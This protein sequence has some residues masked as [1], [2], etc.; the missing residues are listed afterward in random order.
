MATQP[1]GRPLVPSVLDRL[2]DD[3]PEQSRESPRARYQVLRQVKEAVRRDLENLLNTRRRCLVLP[4]GCA[5]LPQS[6]VSYGL[7]DLGDFGSAASAGAAGLCDA[8]VEAIRR[9]EPRCRDVQVSVAG[10]A[11]SGEG[12]VRL[13]I[14]ATLDAEPAPEPML[15]ET[16][17]D[18]SSGA[19]QVRGAAR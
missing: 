15:F 19:C 9:F 6:L 14:R 7:P 5:E 11:Q 13:R 8:V 18:P 3:A 16:T 10:E 12:A 4:P 1:G 17:V 2:L